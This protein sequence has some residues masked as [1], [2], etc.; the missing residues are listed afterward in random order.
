M[1]IDKYLNNVKYTT[2]YVFIFILLSIVLY[3]KSYD[4]IN[5]LGVLL[6]LIIS[7][8]ILKKLHNI[9]PFKLFNKILF[10]LIL[11]FSIFIIHSFLY[12]KINFDYLYEDSNFKTLKTIY[13]LSIVSLLILFYILIRLKVNK[14]K[15]K[16]IKLI[17][18]SFLFFFS[19]KL[20]I[21]I[22]LYTIDTLYTKFLSYSLLY[23][24]DINI[25]ELDFFRNIKDVDKELFV[26]GSELIIGK[27]GNSYPVFPLLPG[28]IN[29]LF[30]IF[31]KFL[32]LPIV[33]LN[34]AIIFRN[35]SSFWKLH[36]FEPYQIERINASFISLFSFFLNYI[37]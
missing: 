31:W 27:D 29:L 30:V 13:I 11:I 32:G 19:I 37:L 21:S 9:Y 14:I 23:E 24:K 26:P 18:L 36:Y 28:V 6:L 35:A 3:V 8:A 2:Y 34:N 16:R 33:S 10:F 5:Y 4:I 7:L 1:K 17:L 22:P 15:Y 12:L 25:N 20:Y